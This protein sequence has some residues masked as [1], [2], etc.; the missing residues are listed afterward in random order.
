MSSRRTIF[1]L[2]GLEHWHEESVDP[3]DT[4][5]I[6]VAPDSIEEV[7]TSNGVTV[8]V[9]ADS[10]LGRLLRHPEVV[11]I[12]DKIAEEQNESEAARYRK[13]LGG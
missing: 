6:Q 8:W 7:D 12:L 10:Q 5:A 9:K 1:A 4:V 2:N 11:T 3:R 13:E